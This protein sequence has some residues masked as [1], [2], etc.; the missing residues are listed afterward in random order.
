MVV[1]LLLVGAILGISR[2]AEQRKSQNASDAH[3]RSSQVA[4]SPSGEGKSSEN[5]GN[6]EHFTD[7]FL[8]PEG[9]TAWALLLTLIVIAWQST[10][11]RAATKATEDSI[12]LQEAA[13]EQWLETD[14][15]R[16]EL[17]LPMS[18]DHFLYIRVGIINRTQ[19]PI[20]IREGELS[21]IIRDS[22][23]HDSYT[24]TEDTF[25]TPGVPHEVSG[26][27]KI[28]ENQASDFATEPLVV[29]VFGSFIHTG[30][31]KRR[32]IQKLWGELMCS[33]FNVVFTV[34]VHMN[35]KQAN[36]NQELWD[37][38]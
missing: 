28:T 32:T 1:L 2:Y 9:A 27:L 26:W 7:T 38:A 3:A 5:K 34:K 11:S 12:R 8:W 20:T 10:E 17:G 29:T 13:L 31:L 21:F 16:A 24:F 33:E 30:A 35:P 19:Y 15:W 4:I 37:R 36:D 18:G 25:L 14:N 22:G 6:A 23:G